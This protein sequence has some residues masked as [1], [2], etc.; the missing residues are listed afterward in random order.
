MLKEETTADNKDDI[1]LV[2]TGIAGPDDVLRG[3]LRAWL[4]ALLAG[5]SWSGDHRDRFGVGHADQRWIALRRSLSP[6]RRDP[7]EPAAP[8]DISA[9]ASLSSGPRGTAPH[10]FRQSES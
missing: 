6:C 1:K 9:L 8:Q 3:R 4:A 10:R 7:T 2:E 5:R